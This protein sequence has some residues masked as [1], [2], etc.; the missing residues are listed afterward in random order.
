MNSFRAHRV[1]LEL[2]KISVLRVVQLIDLATDGMGPHRCNPSFSGVGR[3]NA[4]TWQRQHCMAPKFV[5]QLLLVH[6]THF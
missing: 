3:G 2:H 4:Y 6:P 5:A 1:D